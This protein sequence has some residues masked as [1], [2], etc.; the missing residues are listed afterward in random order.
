MGALTLKSFP[1]E[2][3]GW[4][5][6]KFESIDP[7]DGFGSSTR[8]YIS[9]QQIIQIEP[10]HSVNTSKAWLSDK[11]RQ[12]FDGI[13]GSWNITNK[14]DINLILKKETWKKNVKNLLKTIYL[15]EH[16][17]AKTKKDFFL[18]IIFENLGIETLSL[19]K[20]MEQNY[21]FLKL[22][23]AEKVTLPNDMEFD[24]QL[25]TATN[26]NLLGS[27]T[28][29]LLV[30]TNP[31]YEGYQLNLD[32]RQRHLKGNFKCLVLGSLI[33][34]TF[35][36][37][38]IGTNLKRL[39]NIA[40]GN[41]FVCQD[42]KTAK[43]PLLIFGNELYK[44]SDGKNIV[45]MFKTFK[46]ANIFNQT[47]NG[48]NTLNSS[49][50]EVGTQT[51][52]T[53]L[54]LKSQDFDDSSSF[55]FINV[56]AQNVPNLKKI[57]KTKLLRHEI[58]NNGKQPDINKSFLDQNSHIKNNE[59]FFL[60]SFK[61]TSMKQYN[62][63]PTKMFYENEETFINTEGLIKRTNKIITRRK[64]R[65]GWKLLRNLSKY[66]KSSY[67][68]LDPKTDTRVSFNENKQTN[69]IN[70]VNFQYCAVEKLDSSM[71]SL[72]SQNQP[73]FISKVN[74]HFKKKPLKIKTSKVKYWLDDF[75]TGG[76]D[77]YSKNSLILSNCS[78]VLRTQSTNFF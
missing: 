47:W 15:F 49:L 26:P 76:K 75:F 73:F 5:I 25:N 38:F 51:I 8:V 28:L 29:C 62:F 2:L 22:R 58:S 23:R 37:T 34:L 68:S 14:K 9:K 53:F 11:G 55:Y 50:N 66:F 54:P 24:F 65:E 48:I 21:P 10:D 63:L 12:F 7:T 69:F 57:T 31:R 64:T 74:T 43:N 35:P 52:G 27:S 4:D 33:D 1:F 72:T 13:F 40:E 30:G 42:F 16:C 71:P 45:E 39:K 67:K 61:Q 18:T 77:E 17:S 59:I 60:K 20:M 6:E 36:S 70:F 56:N 46:Y 44:Q 41:S 78:K 3:R 19:L 32:L